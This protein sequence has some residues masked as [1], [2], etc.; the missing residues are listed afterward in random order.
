MKK[1]LMRHSS[2]NDP[3]NVIASFWQ[4]NS[5]SPFFGPDGVC[6]LGNAASYAINIGSPEDAVAGVTFA[7]TRNVR[8]T[9]K[10]TGHDYLGRSAGEGSLAL[11][12]HNLKGIDFVNYSGPNYT[13]PAFRVGAGVESSELLA[14]TSKQGYRVV[15]GG[16]ATVGVTGGFSQGGGHSSLG[17]SYGLGADQVLEWEVITAT[18]QHLTA[19]PMNEYSDLYWALSGGGPGNYAVVLS[20]TIKAYQDGPVAGASFGFM[21]TGDSRFWEAV[22]AWLQH[23]LVL[24]TIPGFNTAWTHSPLGFQVVYAL[25][26]GG[27]ESDV[28][29][30]LE[31]VMAKIRSLNVTLVNE[32]TAI[33]PNFAES[34]DKLLPQSYSTN[35]SLG[36]RLIPRSLVQNDLSSLINTMRTM[37]DDCS[38][39]GVWVINGVAGNVTHARVG[40]SPASNSVLPAW[41][42]SLFQMNFGVGWP[43]TANWD[44][45]LSAVRLLGKWQG[46]LR[47]ITPG[48]GT[49]MNEATFDYPHWKEDFFGENYEALLAVKEKYDPNHLLWNIGGVGSDK[50]WKRTGDGHL[51]QLE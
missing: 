27:S 25:L 8:L 16:C 36:G 20:M 12:T 32:I 9:I 41:R 24:D 23:T 45:M 33:Y 47:E 19:S 1:I 38:N 17:S 29:S 31:P 51:C 30:A 22:T 14:A 15:V 46:L 26:P 7:E 34:Y 11:W 13:G 50:R 5:C 49:Y 43:A 35:N 40:N 37:A 10:N 39:L 48:G 44:T 18:G 2:L 6:E 28:K 4:N 21:N 42:H 3:V